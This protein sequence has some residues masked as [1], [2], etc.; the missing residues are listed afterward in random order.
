MKGGLL[1]RLLGQEDKPKKGA[2]KNV[3]HGRSGISDLLDAYIKDRHLVSAVFL[4]GNQSKKTRLTT[5][6]VDLDAES[7]TF[8]CEP[9]KPDVAGAA[10]G[11][12]VKMQF[13]LNCHGIR[14]QFECQC[15]PVT[16]RKN[17]RFIWFDFPKG[18]EQI[19][20]R[21][22][23]R[24][25][26]SQ[27]DSIKVTMTHDTNPTLTGTLSDLSASGMRVRVQGI[28]SEKPDRG[29]LYSSCHFV[30]SDGNPIVCSG[31]LM[32]WQDDPEY[33]VSYLGVK[34]VGL[35]GNTQRI[36]NR[37]LTEMQ[38]KNRQYS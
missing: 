32:H 6:I 34:F 13:S 27:T 3:K 37:F 31:K 24:V 11:P 28:P 10:V 38:R 12:L 23:F 17:D 35:D 9:F 36:L 29:E 14:H 8:A 2:A 26:L 1:G 33:K 5:G 18:I 19:Q 22:A 20:L 25:Q 4:D 21:E 15:S 7:Q 16:E 30:L